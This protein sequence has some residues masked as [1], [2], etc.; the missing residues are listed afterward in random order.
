MIK[1]KTLAIF[2]DG[3]YK[4]TYDW[5]GG[6]P[7]SEKEVLTVHV[8]NKSLKYVLFKKKI[9]LTDN[10]DPIVNIEYHFKLV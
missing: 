8:N 2:L 6:M 1:K 7:L 5:E 9:D 4:G 10:K 3:D